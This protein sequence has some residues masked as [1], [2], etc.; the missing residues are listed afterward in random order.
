MQTSRRHPLP[1]ARAFAI[2]APVLREASVELD[3]RPGHRYGEF[4]ILRLLGR[5]AFARVFAARSPNF[6]KPVAVKLSRVPITDEATAI[7]ALRE[8]RILQNLRNPYVVHILDNGLGVDERW[9]M[10]MELLEGATVLDRHELGVAM[11]PARA[12]KIIYEAAVGLDEAHEMGIVHRDIKPENLWITLD[13]TCKVIDFGLARAWDPNSTIGADATVGHMLIGTPHYAQPEQIN[14]GVLVPASDVYSLGTVLYELLT[15]R[16]HLFPD[17]LVPVV[18][19]RL[20]DDPIAWLKAHVKAELIPID[21][22]PEGQ[23]LPTELRE[24]VHW[25]LAR[26]PN[27]RP[28]RGRVAAEHLAWI[29]HALYGVPVA[30]LLRSSRPDGSNPSHL[31][32]PGLHRLGNTPDAELRI[33]SGGAARVHATL[34]WIG[35]GTNA[36]L[37]PTEPHGTV[38]VNGHLLERPVQLVPGTYFDIAGT[39]YALDYPGQ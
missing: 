17:E 2:L 30:G 8:I 14:T 39:R 31:L 6:P 5:G 29:L 28:A 26:D 32:V 12:T 25:M 20:R 1:R 34:D 21:R 23:R 36:V 27:A 13:G 16:S 37:S 7:R 3:L 38:W 10:V 11:D 19:E 18:R 15:G 35:P 4:E 9:Y 22:Y 33:A 24:L